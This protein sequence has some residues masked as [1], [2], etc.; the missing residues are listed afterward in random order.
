MAGTS[1][2]TVDMQELWQDIPYVKFLG[3]KIDLKDGELITTLPPQEHLIGN[4]FLPALHGGVIGA[5]LETTAIVELMWRSK[6]QSFPKPIDVTIDYLRSG[7][8]LETHAN[9]RVVKHGRRVANVQVTAWQDDIDRP[10]ALLHGH[11]LLPNAAREQ[12]A[13]DVV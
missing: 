5:V 7:R 6:F 8:M 9:A 11:F 3:M 1:T 12:T 2:D 13:D 4:Q 10:I